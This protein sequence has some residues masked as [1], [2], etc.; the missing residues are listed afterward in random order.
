MDLDSRYRRMV[1]MQTSRQ[2]DPLEVDELPA[3]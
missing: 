3:T 1:L 2:N